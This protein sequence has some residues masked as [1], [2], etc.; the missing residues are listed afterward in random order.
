[1]IYDECSKKQKDFKDKL[2]DGASAPYSDPLRADV[3]MA[4]NRLRTADQLRKM[5]ENFQAGGEAT[6][7]RGGFQQ[8]NGMCEERMADMEKEWCS[9]HQLA[10]NGSFGIWIYQHSRS[11]LRGMLSARRCQKLS[12]SE[13][14]MLEG[15]MNES[16]DST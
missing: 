11:V 13:V 16:S 4:L 9:T 2:Q 7:S 8:A 14:S 5:R 15:C 12:A 6:V 1:M 3:K 10:V